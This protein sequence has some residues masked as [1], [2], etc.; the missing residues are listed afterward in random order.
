MQRPTPQAAARQAL[1]AL[2]VVI[3]VLCALLAWRWRGAAAPSPA[4]AP[5]AAEWRATAAA[6]GAAGPAVAA[7]AEQAVGPAASAPGPNVRSARGVFESDAQG[8][9]VVDARVRL[10]VESLVALTPADQLAGA[11]ER[12]LQGLPPPAAAAARELVQRYDQYQAAQRTAF[13]PGAAPL[14]P[15]QGLAELD[16]LVALRSSYFGAEAARR[17]FGEEEAVARRLLQLMAED[18]AGTLSMEQKAARAQQRFDE[19]RGAAPA[20]R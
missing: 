2:A 7:V 6:P 16:T 15:E 17:M 8:R 4:A 9:L 14:V 18:R 12:E 20:G 5:S 19:E 13:P 11:V 1:V 3:A 10:A